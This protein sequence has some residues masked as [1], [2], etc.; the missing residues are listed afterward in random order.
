MADTET[1]DDKPAEGA[2]PADAPKKKSGFKGWVG[3]H[4]EEVIVIC[5]VV[6]VLLAWLTLKAVGGGGAAAAGGTASDGSSLP[7]GVPT[8]AYG[9]G[10]SGTVAGYSGSADYG[11]QSMLSNLSTSLDT[12]NSNLAGT[13]SPGDTLTGSSALPPPLA[14]T[15]TAP[16]AYGFNIIENTVNGEKDQVESDGSLY[17]LTPSDYSELLNEGFAK[18]GTPVTKYT[19]QP[20]TSGFVGVNN[21]AAAYA[22]YPTTKPPATTTTT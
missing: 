17:H 12:L 3:A 7:A 4:K 13:G 15:L 18:A 10:S 20:G 9:S 6:G 2:P 21:N 14:S 1:A 16:V 19:Q 5:S 11:L 8:S 22:L